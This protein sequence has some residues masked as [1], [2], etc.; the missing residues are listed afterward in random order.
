MENLNLVRQ[1]L[2]DALGTLDNAWEYFL[3]VRRV[4]NYGEKYL[5]F[6][7][8]NELERSLRDSLI[9]RFEYCVDLFLKFLK[10]YLDEVIKI[11]PAINGPRPVVRA[12]CTAKLITEGDSEESLAMIESRN[13]TLHMYR[14]EIA[15]RLSAL[16]GDYAVVIRRCLNR[17]P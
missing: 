5:S 1:K 16:I 15:E 7:D 17:L 8:N 2:N 12:A 3:E 4:K 14:E 6:M 11:D 10:K 13:M 9:Q